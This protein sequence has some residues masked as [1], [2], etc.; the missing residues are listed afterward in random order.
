MKALNKPKSMKKEWKEKLMAAIEDCLQ[1]L[2]LKVKKS[3]K[4]QKAVKAGVELIARQSVKMLKQLEV[5]KQKKEK[6]KTKVKTPSSKTASKRITK[7]STG[8]RN[9]PASKTSRTKKTAT[10]KVKEKAV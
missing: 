8:K 4:V 7:T 3:R 2:P 6:E 5:E 9:S 10:K 1:T